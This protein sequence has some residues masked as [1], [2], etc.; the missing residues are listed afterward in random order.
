MS[1]NISSPY[2]AAL[3][4]QEKA[5]ND[6]I[7]LMFV[8]VKHSTGHSGGLAG[9]V[10]GPNHNSRPHTRGVGLFTPSPHLPSR[11]P[12]RGRRG[13][14]TQCPEGSAGSLARAQHQH[15]PG[16]FPAKPARVS[17]SSPT[18]EP[19]QLA[20]APAP[21][22]RALLT[23]SWPKA[24]SAAVTPSPTGTSVG[25][26]EETL[27]RARGVPDPRVAGRLTLPAGE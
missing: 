17:Q 7:V 8:P 16:V 12:S 11:V 10:L 1:A 25:A 13:R 15:D 26:T 18:R 4:T 24:R 20:S 22:F 5:K 21:P 19:A 9:G 27:P 3:R 14:P 23:W 2:P 6:E